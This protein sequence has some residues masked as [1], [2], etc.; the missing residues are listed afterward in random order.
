VTV[1]CPTRRTS[2]AVRRGFSLVEAGVSVVIVGAMLVAGLAALAVSGLGV[3][4]TAEG[5]RGRLLAQ[6]LISE[7][8]RQ[9]YDE[10]DE[11]PAFGPELPELSDGSRAAFDDVDDYHGWSASP[12]QYK[13]GTEMSDL[14]GWR[15]SVVVEYVNAAD[16][17]QP[18]GNET[19]V[20]RITVVVTYNNAV[21]ASLTALRT[22]VW[23][24][25]GE[26]AP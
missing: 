13:D 3:R 6:D 8:L 1:S 11:T 15:R 16:P 2:Q 20:K 22:Y 9:A 25:Q 4:T 18:T 7:I 21:V 24:D 14:P 19:G 12:P 5:A 17:N 26:G 23:D 10:P